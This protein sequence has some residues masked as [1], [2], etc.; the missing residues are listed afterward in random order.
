VWKKILRGKDGRIYGVCDVEGPPPRER[1][2]QRERDEAREAEAEMFT[3][4]VEEAWAAVVAQTPPGT[5]G[6]WAVLFD[7][8]SLGG[9]VERLF[10]AVQARS[11]EDSEFWHRRPGLKI[12]WHIRGPQRGHASPWGNRR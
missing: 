6:P 10:R 3:R 1:E 11:A 12:E 7:A 2:P 9:D 4:E 8:A 5:A